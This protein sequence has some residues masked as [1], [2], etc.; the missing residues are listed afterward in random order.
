MVGRLAKKS[1]NKNT[2]QERSLS[3]EPSGLLEKDNFGSLVEIDNVPAFKKR[4]NDSP[5]HTKKATSKKETQNKYINGEWQKNI[6]PQLLNKYPKSPSDFVMFKSL[7]ED[8]LFITSVT[9]LVDNMFSAASSLKEIII[10]NLVEICTFLI[11][12]RWNSI[13]S[14]YLD[15]SGKEYLAKLSNEQVFLFPC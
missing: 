3:T 1:P 12:R 7:M 4:R 10:Y 6:L 13:W 14:N 8:S 15:V 2:K 11:E 5:K 9:D